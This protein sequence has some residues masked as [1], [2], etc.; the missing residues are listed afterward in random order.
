MFSYLYISHH[1]YLVQYLN[2]FYK[3]T[4]KISLHIFHLL[5]ISYTKWKLLG[6]LLSL[7]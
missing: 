2:M 4:Q 6:L 3:I 1:I 7:M 5:K